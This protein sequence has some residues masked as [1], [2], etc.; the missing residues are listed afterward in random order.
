MGWSGG[1]HTQSAHGCYIEPTLLGAL[2][3]LENTCIPGRLRNL[4]G[5]ADIGEYQKNFT[6]SPTVDM[7]IHQILHCPY[8]EPLRKLY[9]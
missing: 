2:I 4:A 5:G 6:T 3:A 7:V 9:L 1:F 8:Q